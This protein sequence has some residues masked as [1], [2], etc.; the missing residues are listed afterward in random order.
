MAWAQYCTV[1][2]HTALRIYGMCVLHNSWHCN[3]FLYHVCTFLK[4]SSEHIICIRMC[5][6]SISI[7]SVHMVV[8]ESEIQ[9]SFQRSF[10][11][12]PA[13]VKFTDYKL[14]FNGR[15][16]NLR[17]QYEQNILLTA[18]SR[19]LVCIGHTL[20]HT[21]ISPLSE[22]YPFFAKY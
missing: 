21:K 17:E 6:C 9:I 7:A 22:L 1:I 13:V 8:K 3:G 19:Y 18:Y 10:K 11:F 20:T 4:I 15:Y 2:L 12:S 16:D 5:M 14:Q